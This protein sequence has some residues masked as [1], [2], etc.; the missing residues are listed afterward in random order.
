MSGKLGRPAAVPAP[1]RTSVGIYGS[2]AGLVGDRL[3][4]WAEHLAPC[5]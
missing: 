3:V 5:W 2:D 1:P 4:V